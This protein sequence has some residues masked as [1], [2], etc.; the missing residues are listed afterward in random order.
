MPGTRT[1]LKRSGGKKALKGSLAPL[2][3]KYEEMRGGPRF[4]LDIFQTILLKRIKYLAYHV[5]L[6]SQH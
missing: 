6:N 2:K 5:F 4:C 3:A 1:G